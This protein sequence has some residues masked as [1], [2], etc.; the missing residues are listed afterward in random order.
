PDSRL[1][2]LKRYLAQ[3]TLRVEATPSGEGTTASQG[4]ISFIDNTV[5]QTTGTIKIKGSFANAD[6]QLWP[7]QFVKVVVTLA[8][9]PRAIV[10]PTAAVQKNQQGSYVF[11]VTPGSTVDLRPVRVD[12]A[13][14]DETVIAEGLAPNETVVTDGHIRLVPGS[15]VSIKN[16]AGAAGVKSAP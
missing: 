12:R 13:V 9:E 5:D 1:V 3:G 4:R 2:A 7:G 6:R 11:V 10:V 14:G 16:G 8:T 15:R